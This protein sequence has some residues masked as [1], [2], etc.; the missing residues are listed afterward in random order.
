MS[1]DNINMQALLD[2]FSKEYDFLYENNDNVAGY[3]EAL[4]FGDAFI[5]ENRDFV[6]AFAKYR[7]D[8]LTSDRE[9]AAF[10]FAIEK[11]LQ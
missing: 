1:L 3:N 7:C 4:A 2:D 9:V 10:A 5:I 6:I 8:I 11:H